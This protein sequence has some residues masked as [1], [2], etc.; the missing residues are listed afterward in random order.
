MKKLLLMVFLAFP[1]LGMAQDQKGN[2]STFYENNKVL[3]FNDETSR[4]GQIKQP[5]KFDPR[6]ARDSTHVSA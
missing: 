4:A 1:L 3:N 5:T 2:V 6:T